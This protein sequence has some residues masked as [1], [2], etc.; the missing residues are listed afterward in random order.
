MRLWL[1]WRRAKC[2]RRHLMLYATARREVLATLRSHEAAKLHGIDRHRNAMRP[3]QTNVVR[4][5]GNL[6]EVGTRLPEIRR[7]QREGLHAGD[8]WDRDT[9]RLHGM[10]V[11]HASQGCCNG[12]EGH[13]GIRCL[14]P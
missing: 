10:G 5:S 11:S 8:Q 13:P 7:L 2:R 3:H 12:K 1:A 14:H 4:S 9:E 6:P